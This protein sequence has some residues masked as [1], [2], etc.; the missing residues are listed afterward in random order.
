M[1]NAQPSLLRASLLLCL[2]S[3]NCTASADEVLQR[4][5]QLID[6]GKAKAAYGLLAPLEDTRA[7][8]PLFDTLLGIAAVD[9]GQH[10]RGVFAL[11]R[12][13]SVEP[14][15]HRARAEIARA[16]L[17][18][19][20][21]DTARQELET[22]R[23]QDVPPEVTRNIDRYLD[24]VD[25]ID[26][27]TRTTV[28]GYLEGTLGHDNNLNAGPRQGSIAIPAFGG[29][30]FTI[31]DDSRASRSL[32]ATAAG[33]ATLRHPINKNI[34][35]TAGVSGWQKMNRHHSEFDTA[36]VDANAGI[37]MNA[38][39]NTWSL[40]GQYNQ[41]FL[42]D[43]RY[44]RASGLT[45]QW[46]HDYDARNQFT[47]FVQYAALGYAGQHVRDANRW[48]YGAGYAHALR[49]GEILYGS[50]YGINEREKARHQP[51]LGHKGYGLRFGAQTSASQPLV[52]FASAA[53]EARRY[54]GEEAVFMT[55]RRD[56]QFDVNL[57]A[58][59]RFTREWSL[60]PRASYI[61][62]RSNID[63]NTYDRTIVSLT[64][65]RDF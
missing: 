42:D 64:L 39:R 23:A 20:E 52:L 5:Q 10:S 2:L 49:S 30:A 41:F 46:Q 62:N 29:L 65:R 35:L 26:T 60:T 14:G 4:A 6:G 58:T 8:E 22:V 56:R 50:L 40:T 17:A 63:L 16:Y 32:F 51:Q 27:A 45:A 34:A 9:S 15:N 31:D 54:G 43:D 11:E 55:T 37:V 24:A 57:G 3:M 12:V 36:A 18:L 7:G 59:W 1:K 47:T 33:G 13:L 25:R 38:E 61:K 28:R 53:F 21:T 19:G 44:R 48:V